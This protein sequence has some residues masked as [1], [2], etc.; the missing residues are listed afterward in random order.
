MVGDEKGERLISKKY[1]AVIF[2]LF[3]TLVDKLSLREHKNML[4]QMASVL[5][6]PTDDFIKL[7][8]DTFNERGLG[9]FQS[10]K[11]N[12]DYICQ[13]LNLPTADPQAT[14]A[15]KINI[16]YTARSMKPRPYATELLAQLKSASYKTGLITNCGAEIPKITNDMPFAPWLDVA[17]FSSLEGV[18]KPDPHIYQI[19]VARL[20]VKPEDCLYI[21]DGDSHE[22]TGASQAGM[23]PVLIRNPDENRTDVHRIDFEADEWHGPIISSL[24]EVL[25]LIK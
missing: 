20:G 16:E 6:V 24:Q 17:V 8:F 3:G 18:Q 11:E 2:D 22:L 9:I 14:R 1:Q 15:A 19:A 5:S 21:G 23:Y 10:L 13:K 7:W 12:I 4:G 25:N